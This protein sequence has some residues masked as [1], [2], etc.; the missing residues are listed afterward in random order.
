MQKKMGRLRVDD[1]MAMQMLACWQLAT[2]GWQ[3]ATL[4]K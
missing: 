4:K 1:M 3:L 2:L